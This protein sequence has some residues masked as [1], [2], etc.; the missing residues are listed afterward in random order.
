[1]LILS[2]K[3]GHDGSIA[4]IENGNLLFSLES[5]KDSFPRYDRVTPS[6]AILAF[7]KMPRMP[8]CI[9]IS[10]WIKGV[11]PTDTPLESG[12]FGWESSN[13]SI[14]DEL[15]MGK[16][17]KKFTSSHE[18]SHIMCAYG[19]SP[20]PQGKPV[21]CLVWEGTLGDFYEIDENVNIKHLGKVLTDPGNKYSSL[22]MIADKNFPEIKGFLRHEDAGKLMALTAYS[23]RDGLDKDEQ[24]LISRILDI[25]EP[26]TNIDKTD[27]KNSIFYN[28][29]VESDKF[30]NLS[31]KFSDELFNRFFN[32]AKDN[33]RKGYPLLI[34]GG[35]GLN[36]DW[37]SAWRE[38]GLFEDVFVPPC[39]NDTG[40]AIGTAIDANFHISGNA[41]I[42]WNVYSGDEFI[43]DQIDNDY[44]VEDTFSTDNVAR[45]LSEGNIIAWVQ[46]KCEIGPRA[47]GNR[48]ILAAPFLKSMTERL[49]KIKNREG[50]RP[51]API[52]L[53]EEAERL[54]G[55]K[56]PSPYM[57]YFYKVQDENLKAITHVDGSARIQTV[58]NADNEKTYNL[59]KSFKELTGYGVLCNTSL[60]FNGKGFINRF[61]DLYKY[62][63]SRNLDGFVIGDKFYKKK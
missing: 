54:F 30:K 43:T 27:Y 29:G 11:H 36:C 63:K 20:Y 49:N 42:N 52:C 2:M 39:A 48:S 45:F 7:K 58:T 1:M 59:L 37:N 13:C 44:F 50:F 9:A 38:S 62:C 28:I 4:A 6:L 51:I 23:K 33:L 19:M 31:G 32:F 16:K 61:S 25:K 10:G 53:A 15:F 8:D 60:N 56:T 21:Y 24:S 3:P 34:S 17:L 41:K 55:C 40:S 12:Y 57:L 18:R 26:I 5:E 14:S 46:G 47:L 35:C 22:Y